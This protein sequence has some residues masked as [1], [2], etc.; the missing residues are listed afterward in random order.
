MHNSPKF[1]V[2]DEVVEL[3]AADE[4]L[5][6][7]VGDRM[8]PIIAPVSTKG[9]FLS[10]QRLGVLDVKNTKT[11][12][13]A[14][15]SYAFVITAVSEDYSRGLQIAA[16]VYELLVGAHGFGRIDFVDF[17]ERVVDQKYL[18]TVEFSIT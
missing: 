3:L 17:D 2:M 1:F 7:L 6:A 10:Y 4:T 14:L 9:D 11:P 16:R 15:I 5:R 13:P 12:C 18:Q 8:F